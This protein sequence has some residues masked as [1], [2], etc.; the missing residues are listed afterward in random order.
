M[1]DR[2]KI[3]ELADEIIEAAI[4]ANQPTP[5]RNAI[6]LAA[7]K[8]KEEATPKSFNWDAVG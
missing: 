7:T 8:I 6:V 1:M 2:K 3:V 5:E 4:S